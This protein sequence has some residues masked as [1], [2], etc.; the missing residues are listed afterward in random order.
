[1]SKLEKHATA[2]LS[3]KLELAEMGDARRANKE[4]AAMKK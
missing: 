2:R 1:V 3:G 4:Q